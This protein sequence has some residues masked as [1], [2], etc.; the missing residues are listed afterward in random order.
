MKTNKKESEKNRKLQGCPSDLQD[1]VKEVVIDY[2]DLFCEY[3]KTL[4][5]MRL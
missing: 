2:W 3:G 1:M 5:G 4:E